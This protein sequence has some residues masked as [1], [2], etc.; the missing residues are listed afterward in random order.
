MK[1]RLFWLIS[2]AAVAGYRRLPIFGRIPG[3]IA[4]IRRDGG[5]LGI[6][7]SDGYGISMLGGIIMPWETPEHALRREVF[8]ES[9]LTIGSA[10]RLFEYESSL[11]YPA[12]TTVFEA[13]AA[14][15]AR[16][17]WEGKVGVFSLA[18]L[19]QGII[20]SQR[21]VV[22]YLKESGSC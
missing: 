12:R 21:R 5:F 22:E 11:L 19:E 20:A 16:S 3:A 14:G 1:S 18:E 6:K 7:R 8:E 2:R 4:I 15:T 10:D 9:G 17:S 13:E